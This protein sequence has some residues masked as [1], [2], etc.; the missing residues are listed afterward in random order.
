MLVKK[1]WDL[2]MLLLASWLHPQRCLS[3]AAIQPWA[4][5]SHDFS[6]FSL[7]PGL[8]PLTQRGCQCW[9][10]PLRSASKLLYIWHS[11]T[12]S[13]FWAWV[14]TLGN[15]WHTCGSLAAVVMHNSVHPSKPSVPSPG[16]AQDLSSWQLGFLAAKVM[17]MHYCVR[18]T[19]SDHRATQT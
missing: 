13:Y 17:V 8:L 15:D 6:F 14:L 18:A 16:L 10:R 9:A 5:L 12:V 7:S 1:A 19:E 4:V 2:W 3:E 11:V